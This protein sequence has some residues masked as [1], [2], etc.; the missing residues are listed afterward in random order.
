MLYYLKFKK[1]DET[2]FCKSNTNSICDLLCLSKLTNI[3]PLFT[4]NSILY[5]YVINIHCQSEPKSNIGIKSM[6]VNNETKVGFI[7]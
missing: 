5:S 3:S 7:Y 6:K 2:A 1:S 4:S